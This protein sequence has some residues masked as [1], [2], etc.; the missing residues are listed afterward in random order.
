MLTGPAESASDG[1]SSAR[2]FDE[3]QQDRG[4]ATHVTKRAKAVGRLTILDVVTKDDAL[5]RFLV[6]LD[7][8]ALVIRC[9]DPDQSSYQFAWA[10][11]YDNGST[12]R[13]QGILSAP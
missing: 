7:R 2:F 10:S 4:W 1:A 3:K 13:V 9:A 5:A 8:T 11:G 12:I 6:S